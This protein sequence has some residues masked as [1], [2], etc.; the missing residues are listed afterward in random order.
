MEQDSRISPLEAQIRE[1]YGRL[2]YSHKTQ[3]KC[4][5]IVHRRNS[6]IKIIQIILS[7][8]TTC[9]IIAVIFS[10]GVVYDILSSIVAF[11][12]LGVNL[13]LKEYDLGSIAQRH[14]DAA[15]ELWDLREKYLSLLTDLNS[16]VSEDVVRVRRDEL[17][18]RLK[19][20]YKGSPRTNINAYNKARKGIIENEEMYFTNEELNNMLPDALKK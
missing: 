13:Y 5:D 14:S 12:S 19:N 7:A 18:E 8:L 15:N 3:E 9:G 4:A 17:Q 2:V 20:V 11:I 1:G 16:G 6:T 10:E